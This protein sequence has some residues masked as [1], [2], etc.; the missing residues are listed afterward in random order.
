M[1]LP[2]RVLGSGLL[3]SLFCLVGV[4][5]VAGTDRL[6]RTRIEQNQKQAM[7]RKLAEV[8]PKGVYDNDPLS[9][10]LSVAGWP[11]DLAHKKT[12][13]YRAKKQERPTAMVIDTYAPQGYNGDIRLLIALSVEGAVL[14]VRVTRHQETPGL[15][16]RIEAAKS[17]WIKQFDEKS[18]IHPKI[19]HWAVKKDGGDFDQLSGATITPRA[20]VAAVKGAL[21][22]GL[23]NKDRIFEFESG[24]SWRIHW[25]P[26]RK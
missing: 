14:G 23:T 25:E 8:L 26:V 10:T 6:T 22:F 16:D 24:G 3:L 11:G 2:R 4:I 20:V 7:L 13:I 5:L 1:T 17:V 19:E 9:D 18:L 21:E 15:G 12:R